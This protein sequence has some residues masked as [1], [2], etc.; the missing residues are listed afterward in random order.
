MRK[1]EDLGAGDFIAFGYNNNGGEPNEII[2]T[3][4][5]IADGEDLIV[6]FIYGSHH[7]RSE[8]VKRK[9]VLA[10]G[11]PDDG[12]SKL[13]GWRGMF[14]IIQEEHP[15]VKEA[16]MT[17]VG[18]A[19]LMDRDSMPQYAIKKSVIL[20]QE[21]AEEDNDLKAMGIDVKVLREERKEKFEE[22]WLPHL[23]EKYKDKVEFWEDLG[24]YDIETEKFGLVWFYPKAN[25]V[26]LSKLKN[27]GWRKPGLKWIV[28]NLFSE[29]E[30]TEM[31]NVKDVFRK[32][33]TQTI[34]KS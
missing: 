12:N 1:V 7:S 22:K 32:V 6:H 30:R 14:D 4:I 19:P 8:S 20:K 3:N 11:N 29:Q 2:V 31:F 24:R 5:T 25:S 9:D 13:K 26:F 18:S 17:G 27:K 15:L 16:K 33:S 23:K 34:I 21:A 10:I 28:E